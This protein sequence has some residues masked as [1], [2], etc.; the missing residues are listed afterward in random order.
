MQTLYSL[1]DSECCACAGVGSGHCKGGRE[2]HHLTCRLGAVHRSERRRYA[3][4]GWGDSGKSARNVR[5]HCHVE[6]TA[7]NDDW[8]ECIAVSADGARAAKGAEEGKAL[9][10]DLPTGI[11]AGSN[12]KTMYSG[13]LERPE[14]SI[15]IRK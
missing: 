4:C 1:M 5:T 2:S 9:A 6:N 15:L 8:V 11:A 3:S 14:L 13:R 10:W 12:S 7:Q